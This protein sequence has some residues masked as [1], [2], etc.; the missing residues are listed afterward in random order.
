MVHTPQSTTLLTWERVA[1][2]L[3]GTDRLT[4]GQGIKQ[5]MRECDWH[6]ADEALGHRC[7]SLCFARGHVHMHGEGGGGGVTTVSSASLVSTGHLFPEHRGRSLSVRDSASSR[8]SFPSL[9][10]PVWSLSDV[11]V[12]PRAAVRNPSSA[13]PP[14]FSVLAV[15]L[16]RGHSGW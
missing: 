6:P 16:W 13:L 1:A 7:Q 12:S 5:P 14:L 8:S 11:S 2:P 10:V 3:P 15:Y 9:P 4:E